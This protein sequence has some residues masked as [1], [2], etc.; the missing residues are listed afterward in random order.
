MDYT[1]FAG[2]KVRITTTGNESYEGIVWGFRFDD[3]TNENVLEVWTED[4]SFKVS[5]IVSIVECQ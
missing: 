2:L 4:F 3:E 1:Q 5:D